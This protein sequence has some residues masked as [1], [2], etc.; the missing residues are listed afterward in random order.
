MQN[1]QTFSPQSKTVS[2]KEG[3]KE[4]GNERT[5]ASN[6]TLIRSW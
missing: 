1:K 2:G 3:G 4:G 6:H 5:K